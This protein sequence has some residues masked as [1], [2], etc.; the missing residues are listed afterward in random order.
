M[1]NMKKG[2]RCV[3]S[4]KLEEAYMIKGNVITANIDI[5]HIRSVMQHFIVIHDEPLF[6]ILEV[7]ADAESEKEIKPCVTEKLH[8]DVY[9][10]DGCSKEQALAIMVRVGDILFHD[11]I[12]SFGYGGHKSGDEIMFGKYNVLTIFSQN[13]DSYFKFFEVHKIKRVSKLI[14]AWDTFTR[15]MPGVS[16]RIVIDGKDIFSIPELFKDWGM[17]LAEQREE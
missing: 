4:E 5:N 10:I 7:P 12:S 6:F 14:T 11:G 8:K 2:C 17:Y 16:E 15:E 13:T 9:Y 1:L 3:L